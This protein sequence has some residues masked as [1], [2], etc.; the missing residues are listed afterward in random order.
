[1]INEYFDKIFII[2]LDKRPDRLELMKLKCK[3]NNISNVER[4][5]GILIQSQHDALYKA[6]IKAHTK[7]PQPGS[8]G[9]AQTLLKILKIS[10]DL[11]YKRILILQDDVVFHKQFS[12]LFPIVIKQIPEDWKLLYL[13]ATQHIW[14]P[15]IE[16]QISTNPFYQ[17]K[18]TAGAFAFGIDGSIFEELLNNIIKL[19]APVDDK[20]LTLIQDKY[21]C[22]VLYPNLIAA[23]L[24]SSDIR[25]A[26]DQKIVG[27][28]HFRWTLTNY[29]FV[30]II[31][32]CEK[33]IQTKLTIIPKSIL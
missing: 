17:A 29:D 16:K 33:E 21:P 31:K 23:D 32:K 3:K 2:N 10:M 28:D 18:N 20:I 7:K 27:Q 9:F 13:G 22:P 19:C 1:M 4:T 14:S 30:T 11:R 26:R 15:I 24:S 6:A 8:V 12:E 25:E 5:P